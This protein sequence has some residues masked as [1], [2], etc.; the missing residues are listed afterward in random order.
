MHRNMAMIPPL[1]TTLVRPTFSFFLHQP[2]PQY[3]VKNYEYLSI[4]SPPVKYTYITPSAYQCLYVKRNGPL[5]ITTNQ[6]SVTGHKD[7]ISYLYKIC[8][9]LKVLCIDFPTIVLYYKLVSSCCKWRL[10]QDRLMNQWLRLG[11]KHRLFGYIG[12]THSV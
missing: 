8:Q 2:F 4:P 7:S 9:L 5:P 12:C 6:T 3:S 1:P 11:L 10:A